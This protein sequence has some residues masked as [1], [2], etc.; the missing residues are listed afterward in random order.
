[1][2]HIRT[3]KTA[4]EAT[5]VQIVKYVDRKTIIVN[6]L[7]SAHTTEDIQ[8]LKNI[9]ADW[10]EKETKQSSLFPSISIKNSLITLDRLEYIGVRFTFIYEVLHKI[11]DRFKFF[12]FNNQLLNDLVIIR[13]IEPASKLRSLELMQEYFGISHRRQSFYEALP[14]LVK[15]KNRVE[16][17]VTKIAIEEFGFNF[18]LVFYDVTTLYFES[19]EAD[20]LRKNGFSK[21][22]KLNQPQIVIGLMVNGLG[23]PV[24]YEIF[25]GNKFEG[26]TMIPVIHEFQKKHDVKTLTVVVDSAMLSLDNIEALK[27]NNLSYIVGARIANLSISKIKEISLFLN[28]KDCA[29]IRTQTKHGTLIGDFSAKRYRKD[30]NEMEKQIKKAE[31]YL[32]KP[33]DIKRTKFLKNLY[34]G[35]YALNTE[36]KEKTEM[37]LGIKGYYTN[38]NSEVANQTIIDRYHQLWHVEQ[39]FRIAKNDLQTRPIFH[40]KQDAIKTH[41]L[42]CFMAL[43]VSKYIEIKTGLS[44]RAAITSLKR[45]TDARMRNTLTNEE[46]VL[47]IKLTENIITVLQKLN[48]QY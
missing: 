37:L 14:R 19:F 4:S 42:I 18:S 34:K 26:H 7:G 41:I 20:E 45:I 30:K 5:A 8:S 25:E 40:F 32:K 3:T 24:A 36:L 29:S 31:A 28:Q 2:Y 23:F 1:M 6:H 35:K 27:Q 9:A 44:I 11:L 33:S 39:A 16:K 48:L 38:L 10:I 47:R 43:A 13:L 12:S 22:N 46:H 21:D 17:L 15:L